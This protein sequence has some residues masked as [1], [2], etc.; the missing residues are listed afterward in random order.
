M[1]RK[2]AIQLALLV[3]VF[4][5]IF[6]AYRVYFKTERKIEIIKKDN[7][8]ETLEFEKETDKSNLIKNLKYT[9]KDNLGNEYTINSE[10]G[11]LDL[12][13]PDIILMT[14]VNAKI[15]MNNSDPIFIKS[16]F[17]EYNNLSYATTFNQN[18]SI[19]YLEN[20]ALGENLNISIKNSQ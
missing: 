17:A 16:D 8:I 7:K 5:L 4:F 12:K 2:T 10:Y 15:I 1:W 19:K 3:L 11:E 20:K 13:N 6:I 18:V 9:S 14:N